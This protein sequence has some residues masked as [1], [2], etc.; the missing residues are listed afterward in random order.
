VLRPRLKATLVIPPASVDG[1]V[2]LLFGRKAFDISLR[3]GRIAD[4]AILFGRMSGAYTPTEIAA[5]SGLLPSSVSSICEQLSALG[6][7]YDYSGLN[8]V[9]SISRA[10]FLEIYSAFAEAWRFDMFRHPLFSRINEEH[11]FLATAAEYF[12]LIRDAETHIAIALEH[13]PNILRKLIE[14]YLKSE[15]EH[16]KAIQPTLLSAFGGTFYPDCLVPLAATEALMLKSRELARSNTLVYL[17]CCSF[18]EARTY[19]LKA[20]ERWPRPIQ[21]LFHAFLDHAKEDVDSAH[22]SL[23]TLA[24]QMTHEQ[25]TAAVAAQVLSGVHEFKHYLDNLNFEI[26][27]AYSE[28]GAS[29]PRLKQPLEDFLSS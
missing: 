23:F 24:V 2:G 7:V 28:P 26:L 8:R 11:L 3:Q 1:D 6:L 19:P 29:I 12:Q 5:R 17:A 15:R 9:E 4:L 18:S 20:G 25:V 22:G 14:E 13:A 21:N 16:Y 27:R 10:G